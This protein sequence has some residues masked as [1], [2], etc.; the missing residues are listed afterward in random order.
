MIQGT[1]SSVGKSLVVA[2]LCRLLRNAGYRVAPFKAQNMSLNSFVTAEGGEMGRAQVVQAQ[3]AGIAPSVL[4]N[5]ILLKPS[6]NAHSQLIVLGE[7]RGTYTAEQYYE[8]VPALEATVRD[9]YRQLAQQYE[10]VVLEGAGSPAEI[11]LRHRDLVN[12]GMAH[13]AGA[14]VLLVGDIDKGGVFAALLGTKMLLSPADQQMIRGVVINKFRGSLAVLEPGLRQLEHLMGVPCLGVIPYT[15]VQLDEEDGA[16]EELEAGAPALEQTDT[17]FT[18]AVVRLPHISNFTDFDTLARLPRTR[19]IYAWQPR[20]LQGAALVILP[21]SKNTVAD[22][23]HLRT[24]GMERAVCEHARRGGFVIGICGGYQMLGTRILDPQRVESP[25]AEVEG[26]GLLAVTTTFAARKRTCQVQ[27]RFLAG[28]GEWTRD[29]AG[30]PFQGYEIHMGRSQ[31]AP[32]VPPLVAVTRDDGSQVTDGAASCDGRVI[33]TYVHGLLDD[34]VIAAGLVNHVR[35]MRGLPEIEVSD[36]DWRTSCEREHDRW[37]EILGAN[38]DLDALGRIMGLD[39]KRAP[40]GGPAGA[41]GQAGPGVRD[42]PAAGESSTSF[43]APV[44]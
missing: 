43:I 1:A 16:I 36:A 31:A 17:D 25:V 13:L 33:G 7:A 10:V 26:M 6:G 15:R 39:L 32:G 22:L 24:S 12:M 37:A 3:A 28:A 40:A 8:L 23:L 41:G 18:V 27:G 29:L 19:M 11:N 20:D 2:G 9:A 38:L 21:G 44:R 34:P 30:R 42:L 4:M 35:R 14:P 5:P